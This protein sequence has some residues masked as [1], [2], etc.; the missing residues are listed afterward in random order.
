MWSSGLEQLSHF[1]KEFARRRFVKAAM[2]QSRPRGQ[3]PCHLVLPRAY[4]L[5]LQKV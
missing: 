1:F 5:L 3:S 2:G 4:N